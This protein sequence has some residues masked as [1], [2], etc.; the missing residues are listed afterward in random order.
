[1]GTI[2]ASFFVKFLHHHLQFYTRR[3]MN[4]YFLLIASLQLVQVLT[5][6]NPATTWIPLAFIFAIS[7]IKEGFDDYHRYKADKLANERKYYVIRNGDKVTIQSQDISVG[8]ILYL[9]AENEVPCDI[10]LLTTSNEDGSCYIEV[11][12][13]FVYD[14]TS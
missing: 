8:D 11:Y 10:V 7:A 9:E 5:P 3:F 12:I 13:F 1:M 14:I 4:L 6:V 2:W